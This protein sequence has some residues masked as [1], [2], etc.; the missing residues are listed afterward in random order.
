MQALD[1]LMRRPLILHVEDG[2]AQAE[3]L[4]IILEGNGFSVLSAGSAKDALKMFREQ[5]THRP[6]NL[7][8]QP[9]RRRTEI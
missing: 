7:K 6:N 3:V 9:A 8:P 5:L 2:K 4:R 1:P